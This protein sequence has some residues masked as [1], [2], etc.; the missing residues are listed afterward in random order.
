MELPEKITDLSEYSILN[1][2]SS[3]LQQGRKYKASNFY[4]ANL[5]ITSLER[6]FSEHDSLENA[7]LIKGGGYNLPLYY[8]KKENGKTINLNYINSMLKLNKNFDGTMVFDEYYINTCLNKLKL[9]KTASERYDYYD[10]MSDENYILRNEN[11]RN[12]IKDYRNDLKEGFC[13]LENNPLKIVKY[14]RDYNNYEEMKIKN[15]QESFYYDHYFHLN[16]QLL[17]LFLIEKSQEKDCEYSI[18][19][20]E[21]NFTIINNK[22]EEVL[23]LDLTIYI[24][25]IENPFYSK[26]IPLFDAIKNI[27]N[28]MVSLYKNKELYIDYCQSLIVEKEKEAIA[29]S[30]TIDPENKLMLNKKRI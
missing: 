27:L 5:F 22:N 1:K 4:I 18:L 25:K 19:S 20:N 8:F 21:N 6:F 2:I 13:F 23:H 30:I 3:Y 11:I 7:V 24:S 10:L 28:S 26:E 9:M 17:L 16:M 29:K 15:E 14:F 12:L